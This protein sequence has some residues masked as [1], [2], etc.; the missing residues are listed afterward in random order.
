MYAKVE[1]WATLEK[2]EK[3]QSF[4]VTLTIS[5]SRNANV[6]WQARKNEAVGYESTKEIRMHRQYGDFP[7]LGAR[8]EQGQNQAELRTSKISNSRDIGDP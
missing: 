7:G 2:C 4:Q 1:L 3:P 8:G 5:V 6:S